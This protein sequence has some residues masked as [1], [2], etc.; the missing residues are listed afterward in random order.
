VGEVEGATASAQSLGMV[1]ASVRALPVRRLTG[2]GGDAL[3]RFGRGLVFSGRASDYLI[4][5]GKSLCAITRQS[6]SLAREIH[7]FLGVLHY[8]D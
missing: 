6:C 7:L 3:L 5:A 2:A 1:H 8:D 4:P